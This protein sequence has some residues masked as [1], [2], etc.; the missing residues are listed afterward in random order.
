M[1]VDTELRTR[2]RAL[3]AEAV[4]GVTVPEVPREH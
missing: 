1:L 2:S 4:A 3:I